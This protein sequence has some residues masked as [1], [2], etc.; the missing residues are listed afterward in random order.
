MWYRNG[1]PDPLSSSTSSSEMSSMGAVGVVYP[2]DIGNA[3]YYNIFQPCNWTNTNEGELK[4]DI[5]NFGKKYMFCP[6]LTVL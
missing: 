2:K 3:I 6:C 5:H 1:F 4:N